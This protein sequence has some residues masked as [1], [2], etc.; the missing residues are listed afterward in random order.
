MMEKNQRLYSEIHDIWKKFCA[1]IDFN[2][3]LYRK[4]DIE[5]GGATKTLFIEAIDKREN[6]KLFQT[7]H[8]RDSWFEFIDGPNKLN[9]TYESSVSRDIELSIWKKDF[10][11]RVFKS[12]KIYSGNSKFDSTFSGYSNDREFM[13]N[14]FQ[15]NEIQNTLLKERL[16]I[17][18]V[19]TENKILRISLKNM[20]NTYY[21]IE[22]LEYNYKI[23]KSI[24]ERILKFI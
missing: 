22:E 14:I 19:T 13:N 3:N 9:C 8:Q 10:F 21:T 5:N 20:Y 11:E 1:R 12:N 16:L 15:D 4:S 6:Y 17:L 2:I 7:F 18:N 23:F 24:V